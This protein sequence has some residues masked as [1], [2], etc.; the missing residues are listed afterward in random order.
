MC[1]PF[2]VLK[3]FCN[4]RIAAAA[5]SS[6]KSIER[7]ARPSAFGSASLNYR[8]EPRRRRP[9][10]IAELDIGRSGEHRAPYG[11]PYIAWRHNLRDPSQQ[12]LYEFARGVRATSQRIERA[13]VHKCRKGEP[14]LVR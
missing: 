7:Y 10:L 9:D 11:S 14:F 13:D 1:V 8:P 3:Q 4:S 12:F 2:D 6:G 5:S